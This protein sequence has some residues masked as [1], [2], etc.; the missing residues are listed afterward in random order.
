ML[1]LGIGFWTS[2]VVADAHGLFLDQPRAGLR[3]TSVGPIVGADGAPGIGA[4][5]EW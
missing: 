1:G 3:P 2:N 4:R 5:W